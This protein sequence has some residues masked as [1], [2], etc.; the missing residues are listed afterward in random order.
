MIFKIIYILP[1]DF[2]FGKAICN[3]DTILYISEEF[4]AMK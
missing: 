2:I 3:I 4:V 1:I